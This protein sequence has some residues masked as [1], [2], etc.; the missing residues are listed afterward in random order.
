[1]DD[2]AASQGR[3]TKRARDDDALYGT[4][5]SS[6]VRSPRVSEST[7]PSG[8]AARRRNASAAVQRAV[9]AW[10]ARDHARD[11]ASFVKLMTPC[12]NILRNSGLL[13]RAASA[14]P[15][16][17]PTPFHLHMAVTLVR[18]NAQV[19]VDEYG[20]YSPF[21]LLTYVL[22]D[23]LRAMQDDDRAA[24]IAEVQRLA[25]ACEGVMEAV[26]RILQ[27]SAEK[28][29]ADDASADDAA[30]ADSASVDDSA[31]QKTTADAPQ[32]AQSDGS[33]DVGRA[34]SGHGGDQDDAHE[35]PV[36]DDSAARDDGRVNVHA[37]LADAT[38][39]VR[40]WQDA[41]AAYTAATP[42]HVVDM[43]RYDD[44]MRI[45]R[46]AAIPL[47]RDGLLVLLS[48]RRA[49]QLD[50]ALADTAPSAR[51]TRRSSAATEGAAACVDTRD[52]RDALEYAASAALRGVQVYVHTRLGAGVDAACRAVLRALE[53]DDGDAVLSAARTF[54]TL[55]QERLP[56]AHALRTAPHD[57]PRVW[58]VH[59][60][61]DA[62]ALDEDGDGDV[63]SASDADTDAG[64]DADTDAGADAGTDAGTDADMSAG[65]TDAS[66]ASEHSDTVQDA[67][68]T[69]AYS[70]GTG[71]GDTSGDSDSD[72]SIDGD[73]APAAGAGALAAG[74]P[75]TASTDLTPQQKQALRAAMYKAVAQGR[76]AVGAAPR[77]AATRTGAMA[78]AAVATPPA[79]DATT[80]ADTPHSTAVE[81]SA[82]ASRPKED[83][84]ILE[85]QAAALMAELGGPQ[86]SHAPSS[87]APSVETHDAAAT[88]DA[89]SRVV[90]E[91]HRTTPQVKPLAL[92]DVV[93]R[94][95]AAYAVR[96]A[97]PRL[98]SAAPLTAEQLAAQQ[99]ATN[100]TVN[101]TDQS[102]AAA[103]TAMQ[104][105]LGSVY[106]RMHGTQPE[107]RRAVEEPAV[108]A[109]VEEWFDGNAR[110]WMHALRAAHAPV[111]A[112]LPARIDARQV[113][114]FELLNPAAVAARVRGASAASNADAR[115][116]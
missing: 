94:Q 112:A 38:Q 46:A 106:K 79:P 43:A 23:I 100:A 35:G 99:D 92:Q 59:T 48:P 69:S 97:V 29:A 19:F 49:P 110:G 5:V 105:R 4:D 30:S 54:V 81:G 51:S 115:E 9:A 2:D 66:D 10:D 47:L 111:M 18:R 60:A 16:K 95:T 72:G 114:W 116:T 78:S 86:R 91:V 109:A 82:G 108:E 76:A 44:A 26:D 98:D 53:D 27:E 65:T 77:P 17:P 64:T 32:D 67:S 3:S 58:H 34:A 55:L 24:A 13:P 45:A 89:A 57:A 15:P 74:K 41:V 101:S 1:M 113:M 104:T 83:T 52:A 73:V 25:E 8:D 50:D 21:S 80:T 22:T 20:T 93:S 40:Q 7:G 39:I 37:L 36:L 33:A 6:P 103:R 107:G 85:A 96:A 11:P 61:D 42:D 87:A 68:D 71:S 102:M 70:D 75:S 90:R 28:A 12:V 63:T 31:A 14:P 84:T 56:T 62:L 88:A